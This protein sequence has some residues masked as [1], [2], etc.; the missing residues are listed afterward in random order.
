[1]RINGFQQGLAEPRKLSVQLQMNPRC[2]I[3]ETFKQAF[4]VRV[5]TDFLGIFVQRQSPSDLRKFMREFPGHFTQM[6]QFGIIMIQETFIHVRRLRGCTIRFP[7]PMS[8]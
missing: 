1:M 6:A 7:N 8:F 3:R 2:Q 5:G 4:Y